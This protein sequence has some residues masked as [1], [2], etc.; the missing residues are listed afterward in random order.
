MRRSQ[1]ERHRFEPLDG[2]RSKWPRHGLPLPSIVEPRSPL[3]GDTANL[4]GSEVDRRGLVVTAPNFP[5]H[6]QRRRNAGVKTPTWIDL[7]SDRDLPGPGGR[8]RPIR[9]CSGEKY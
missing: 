4:G 7:E 8:G 5:E 2:A 6:T 3:T 9:R 1:E